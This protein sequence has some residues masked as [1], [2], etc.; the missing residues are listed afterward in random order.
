[1][2][3]SH[4]VGHVE[5]FRSKLRLF[6]D[7]LQNNDLAHFSCSSVVKEEYS[8]AVFTQ[9]ISNIASLSEEFYSR[10]QDFHQLKSLLPLYNSPMQVN[11]ATQPSEIQLELCDLHNDQFLLSKKKKIL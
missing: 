7:C 11:A 10:F 8:S 2:Q 9:F 5:S 4:L 6:K 1:M 3:I